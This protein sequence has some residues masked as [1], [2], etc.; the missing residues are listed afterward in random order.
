VELANFATFSIITVYYAVQL[1]ACLALQVISLKT[2]LAS[3]VHLGLQIP[4]NALLQ[5][6]T[7]VSAVT[8]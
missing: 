3:H 8:T 7:V 5:S 2:E 6:L 4:S 1:F